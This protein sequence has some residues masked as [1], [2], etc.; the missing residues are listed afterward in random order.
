[1]KNAPVL[2]TRDVR[3]IDRMI[4]LLRIAWHA[5]PDMRLTQLLGNVFPPEVGRNAGAMYNTEDDTSEKAIIE[6]YGRL[7]Q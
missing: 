2:V 3:R 1:M 4:E 7:T 5:H 6:T